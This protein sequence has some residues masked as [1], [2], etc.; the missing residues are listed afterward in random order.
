MP[1]YAR[2]RQGDHTI[3]ALWAGGAGLLATGTLFSYSSFRD[4]QAGYTDQTIPLV[5]VG[6]NGA[7]GL[8]LN[9]QHF[10]EVRANLDARTNELNTF[11]GAFF[12][13]YAAH[14]LDYYLFRADSDPTDMR[15]LPGDRAVMSGFVTPD[16]AVFMIRVSF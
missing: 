9:Y 11:T 12:A 6:I 3:G 1:G 10:T 16:S 14:L 13:L 2:Y 7:S 4:A 15:G 8:L 5:T